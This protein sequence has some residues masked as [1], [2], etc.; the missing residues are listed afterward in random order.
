M[1]ISKSNHEKP[2]KEIEE[3]SERN[4]NPVCNL[5]KHLGYCG[6]QGRTV[7]LILTEGT[8]KKYILLKWAVLL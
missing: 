2:D 1:Q 7:K 3:I 5:Q 6:S 4:I 8:E